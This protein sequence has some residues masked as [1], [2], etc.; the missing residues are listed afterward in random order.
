MQRSKGNQLPLSVTRS[1][2][3]ITKKM[4]LSIVCLLLSLGCA[5]VKSAPAPQQQSNNATSSLGPV[6]KVYD[7]LTGIPNS[8]ISVA[9]DATKHIPFVKMLPAALHSGVEMG[10][11]VAEGIDDT[12]SGAI[13]GRRKSGP[14]AAVL[15]PFG[16]FG[17]IQIKFC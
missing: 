17:G 14:L 11:N 5:T 12:L 7:V 4:K 3:N 13:G 2:V 8:V 10:K 1:V 6:T 16:F 9:Q 15:H